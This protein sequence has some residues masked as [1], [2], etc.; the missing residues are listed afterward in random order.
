MNISLKDIKAFIFD[1]DVILTNNLV[2]LDSQKY[3]N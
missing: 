3:S 1:F 2:H